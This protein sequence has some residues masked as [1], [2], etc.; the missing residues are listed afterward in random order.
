[1]NQYIGIQKGK[2]QFREYT[3]IIA[4]ASV[5]WTSNVKASLANVHTPNTYDDDWIFYA[6]SLRQSSGNTQIY[7]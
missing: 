5:L 6:A 1:M 3:N 4:S 7:K 2:E